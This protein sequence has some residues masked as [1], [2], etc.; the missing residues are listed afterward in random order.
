MLI[1]HRRDVDNLMSKYGHYQYFNVNFNLKKAKNVEA[2]P[3]D[4]VFDPTPA[5]CRS[6]SGFHTITTPH[7]HRGN[8]Q[9]AGLTPKP[10]H[11]HRHLCRLTWVASPAVSIDF[12]PQTRISFTLLYHYFFLSTK[13]PEAI[14]MPLS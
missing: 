9:R 1:T 8:S 12:Q 14:P 6:R 4:L 3:A 13:L 2:Y 11:A 7:L 5:C 10:H